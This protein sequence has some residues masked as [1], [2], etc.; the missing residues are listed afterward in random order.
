MA[1]IVI[2]VPAAAVTF[3]AGVDDARDDCLCKVQ[4]ETQ[5]D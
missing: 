2:C 3:E 4:D 1:K 5:E